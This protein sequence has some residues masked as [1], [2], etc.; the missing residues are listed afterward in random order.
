VIRKSSP[1]STVPHE[2]WSKYEK[3]KDGLADLRRALVAFSGGV[4]ST[5]LL[6]AAQEVLGDGVWAVTV[7]SD[8]HPPREIEAAREMAQSLGVRFSIVEIDQLNDAEFV[9]NTPERCYLC[10]K[11]LFLYLKNLAAEEKITAILEG[12]NA[13]DVRDF[14]PGSR[15]T[16]ELGILVP[17]RDAGLG[18][19]EIRQL[20][21]HLDLRTW[22]KPSMAC[23]ASRIPYHNRLTKQKLDRVR[24]AEEK[25]RLWGFR[26]V[27]VRDHG[28]CA[29]IEVE[30]SQ[31]PRLCSAEACER[32]VQEFKDLGYVFV[33]MDLEGYR[34]GSMNGEIST[35]SDK[36]SD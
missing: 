22:D 13:D 30:S 29:R 10:K 31:I 5:L 18:K 3:L 20:S 35:P 21:R 23:L 2:V 34:T 1:R 28:N 4:D 17:L 24:L 12:S 14:R 19:G 16:K 11:R 8:L 32:I 25:L 6:Y 9:R 15:A 36:S 26:Q 33:A 27:R 7:K